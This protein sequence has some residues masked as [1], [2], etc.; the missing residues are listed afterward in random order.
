MYIFCFLYVIKPC[1][2]AVYFYLIG[3]KET[4]RE[5]DTYIV[6]R[7]MAAILILNSYLS[8]VLS[9]HGAERKPKANRNKSKRYINHRKRLHYRKCWIVIEKVSITGV[10]N[11][12]DRFYSRIICA[13]ANDLFFFV[14]VSRRVDVSPARRINMPPRG[15][16]VIEVQRREK[17]FRSYTYACRRTWCVYNISQTH[18]TSKSDQRTVGGGVLLDFRSNKA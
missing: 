5:S 8:K 17:S 16:N 1:W 11:L 4:R 9:F 15:W 6:G 14:S 3:E 12:D 18:T 10:I 13:K 7:Q 2:G